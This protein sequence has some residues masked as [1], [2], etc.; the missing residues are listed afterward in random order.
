MTLSFQTYFFLV[1]VFIR[2]RPRCPMS[3]SVS[4]VTTPVARPTSC[5]APFVRCLRPSVVR[6]PSY[7]IG[8][9]STRWRWTGAARS[10][11]V[12]PFSSL[13]S[14]S[15]SLA[16]PGV[17]WGW[18]LRCCCCCCCRRQDGTWMDDVTDVHVIPVVSGQWERG[19][20]GETAAESCEN[21]GQKKE[22]KGDRKR[23]TGVWPVWAVVASEGNLYA[24]AH[25]ASGTIRY[26]IPHPCAGLAP[27]ADE[28]M[29][30]AQTRDQTRPPAMPPPPTSCSSTCVVDPCRQ[31]Q[32]GV[33]RRARARARPKTCGVRRAAC[34]PSP[35]AC[36]P[37]SGADH[38]DAKPIPAL[39][40][41]LTSPFV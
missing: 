32:A 37:R 22:R 21:K 18:P 7:G 29:P 25:V 15:P 20:G 24:R 16:P 8:L 3:Q 36:I 5:M 40:P 39:S 28:S 4:T 30:H 14:P 10:T 19:G 6:R 9:G 38:T 26:D 41:T 23:H 2:P 13:F 1:A 12:V 27:H 17:G 34:V 11:C 35:A 33:Q 31:R